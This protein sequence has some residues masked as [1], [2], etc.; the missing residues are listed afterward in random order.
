MRDKAKDPV[1]A[2]VL[3]AR[4]GSN[5]LDR[6]V[7]ILLVLG[8]S[9]VAVY[10]CLRILQANLRLMRWA[11][12]R[13]FHSCAACHARDS[14]VALWVGL[15]GGDPLWLCVE[16]AFRLP[17]FDEV[18]HSSRQSGAQILRRVGRLGRAA[19]FWCMPTVGGGGR[20]RRRPLRRRAQRPPGLSNAGL[21]GQA[22]SATAVRYPPA[23]SAG[24]RH[25]RRAATI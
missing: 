8:I 1:D 7:V 16:C 3:M 17:E 5:L 13:L 12:R 20:H 21:V 19:A 6:A 15:D 4:L 9:V 23:V 18:S 14:S 11:I 2:S 22:W 24:G 10:L 25:R